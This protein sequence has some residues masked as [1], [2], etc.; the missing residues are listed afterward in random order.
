MKKE[1]R[2]HKNLLIKTLS[3]IKNRDQ[4][5][6]LNLI[7]LLLIQSFLDVMSIATLMPLLYIFENDI[8]NENINNFLIKYGLNNI[9]LDKG[10]T[11]IYIPLIAISI[12]IISTLTKLF[13][14]YKT[15]NFIESVRHNLSSR[16]MKK[17]LLRKYNNNIETS[18]IAKSIL[19]EVDQF[20][21]IVF[22]PVMWMVTNAILL[23]GII[24]YLLNTNLNASLIS[25][26]SLSFFYIIFHI[27]SKK[28]LNVQ[29]LKSEKSNKGRF[30]TALETFRGIKDVK[31]YSAESYFLK[32]FNTNSKL[33]ANSNSIYS[34]LVASPKYLLEMIVF[35]AL[36]FS[37][38]FLAYTSEISAESIPLLG[39]FAFAAYRAQPAL[40]NVIFG[41]NSLEFGSKII[42]NLYQE[43]IG[44]EKIKDYQ[45]LSNYLIRDS[46]KK[47]NPIG[48]KIEN[49]HFFYNKDVG[50]NNINLFINHPSFFIVAGKSGSGKSTFLNILAGLQTPQQGKL[51]FN[52]K[53]LKHNKPVISFLHQDYSIYDTTIQEN[54]AF[55]IDKH[56][57]NHKLMIKVSKDAGI[58]EYINSLKNNFNEVVGEN[59]YK[60]S[61]G[62]KQRIALARALY[63]KPEIL[64]LDEPTSGLDKINEKKIIQTLIKLSKEITIIMSTHKLNYIPKDTKI[65]VIENNQIKIKSMKDYIF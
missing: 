38:L 50:L 54:I 36:S 52:F 62:Q 43:L 30:K 14:V 20:I 33:F 40:S 61:I 39:T 4:K 24:I 53:T 47:E 35:I 60:L 32:R 58:Y 56:K 57:I 8:G 51:K 2:N 26:I 44:L 10:M 21:I 5:K 28:I 59:G 64:L 37:V 19:S 7:L 48:L 18:N 1:I 25:L 27:F 42:N 63:I 46:S 49:L 9:L 29:G 65:A 13:I 55:G 45:D 16:L 6:F 12:M 17:F 3:V 23:L 41:I 34:T 22:Q 15:N 31:I 11:S